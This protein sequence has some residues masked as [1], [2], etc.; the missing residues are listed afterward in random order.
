MAR[1]REELVDELRKLATWLPAL[2][3]SKEDEA[4]ALIREAADLLD[5]LEERA[6]YRVVGD[7]GPLREGVGVKLTDPHTREVAEQWAAPEHWQD[8]ENV[9]IQRRTATSWTDVEEATHV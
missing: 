4:S 6:E 2:H 1:S 9:R 7:G 5:S 3:P 8:Y